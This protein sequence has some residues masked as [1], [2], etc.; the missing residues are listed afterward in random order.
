MEM[1]FSPLS[2]SPMNFPLRSERSPSLSWLSPFRVLTLLS[3]CPRSFLICLTGFA[4]LL[5]RGSG[6]LAI[7]D[8][9]NRFAAP[10][11]FF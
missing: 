8:H 11:P 2:T 5:M 6:F 1:L 7:A 3:R 10:L 4:F 9:Y